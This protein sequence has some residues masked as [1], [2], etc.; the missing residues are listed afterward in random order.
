[1][2]RKKHGNESG[3]PHL[4]EL[5][6]LSWSPGGVV[7]GLFCKD[8][9]V[10]GAGDRGKQYLPSLS[11]TFFILVVGPDQKMVTKRP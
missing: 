4:W 1:M 7:F 9:L 5:F 8:T 3:N 11:D 2:L 6:L 10:D